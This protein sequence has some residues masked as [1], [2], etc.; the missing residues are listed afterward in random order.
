MLNSHPVFGGVRFAYFFSLSNKVVF[1]T[2]RRWQE[3]N[4]NNV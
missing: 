4:N 2:S 1:N 3:L